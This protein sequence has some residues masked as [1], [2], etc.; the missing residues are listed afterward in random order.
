MSDSWDE[1]YTHF[2]DALEALPHY[3]ALY[4]HMIRMEKTVYGEL[5]ANSEGKTVGDRD[6]YVRSHT[7]YRDFLD[8]LHDVEE[9]KLTLEATVER[10][11]T[12]LDLYR[13]DEST[14][15]EEMRLQR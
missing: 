14:R 15:R 9:R 8:Q 1:I 2:V 11:R 6:A 4:N 3:K 13:T 12:R 7:K 10:G 5:Y